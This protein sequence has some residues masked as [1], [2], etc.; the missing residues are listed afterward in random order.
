[1]KEGIGDVLYQ[2]VKEEPGAIFL[3]FREKLMTKRFS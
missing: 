3:A 1:M 2:S